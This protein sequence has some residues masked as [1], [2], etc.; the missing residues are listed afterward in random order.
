MHSIF[1]GGDRD[2]RGDRNMTRGGNSDRRDDNRRDN[3]RRDGPARQ[4]GEIRRAE[5]AKEPRRERPVKDLEERM[6]KYQAPAGPV[7]RIHNEECLCQIADGFG[8]FDLDL[9]SY[10]IH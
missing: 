3:N 9:H 2:Y 1:S 5:P 7:S 8:L 4:D 10:I 6:P